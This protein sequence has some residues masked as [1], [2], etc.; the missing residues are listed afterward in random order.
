MDHTRAP[1]LEA[2]AAYHAQGQAPFTPPGHKQARGTDPRVLAHPPSARS[3]AEVCRRLDHVCDH[4]RISAQLTHAD[5]EH[6]TQTLLDALH[7]LVENAGALRPVRTVEVPDPP[8]LR[9]EQAM[10]PRDAFFDR[11]EQVPCDAAAAGP[12]CRRG[13]VRRTDTPYR[14]SCPARLPV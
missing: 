11:S 1:V 2:L 14:Y 10:L 7:D 9:L 4:R 13:V 3:F 8:E 5:D 12:G 6:T